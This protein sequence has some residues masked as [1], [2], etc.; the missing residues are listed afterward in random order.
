[1]ASPFRLKQFQVFHHQSPQAVGT[2]A[3]LLGAFPSQRNYQHI[4]EVGCGCG[5][6]SLMLAQRYP[7]AQID[8]LEIDALGVQEAREN[9]AN[10][11]FA[12][13]LKIIA[14]DYLNWSA[15]S[16]FY[17]LITANPPFFLSGVLSPEQKRQQARH[18]AADTLKAWLSK[19]ESQLSPTGEIRLILAPDSAA[20]LKKHAAE[21]GLFLVN[22]IS[23][24]HH[25]NKKA[26]RYL[27]TWS[28]N[29]NANFNAQRLV[30]YAEDGLRRTAE[31][32]AWTS[33]FLLS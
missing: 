33:D 8:A 30:L 1:M 5:I 23:I 11:P 4:L 16:A 26:K 21:L 7:Q 13:Q 15:D 27:L 22:E 29:G 17:D 18:I 19:M 32:E 6:V 25:K 24:H 20:L 12:S 31:F 2:D 10:S 9:A 28:R 3:I 14:A